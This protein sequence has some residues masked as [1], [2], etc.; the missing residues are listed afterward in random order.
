[1]ITTPAPLAKFLR[2]DRGDNRRTRPMTPVHRA[3]LAGR[4]GLAKS[5]VSPKHARA[6]ALVAER[7]GRFGGRDWAGFVAASVQFPVAVVTSRHVDRCVAL[8]IGH[9]YV[10]GVVRNTLDIDMPRS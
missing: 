3:T 10:R 5:R 8:W 2:A 4:R 1:M 6:G 9:H 7:V